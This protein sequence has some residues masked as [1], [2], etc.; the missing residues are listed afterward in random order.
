VGLEELDWSGTSARAGSSVYV[1]AMNCCL[2][3][4]ILL[5]YTVV[6]I[7]LTVCMCIRLCGVG[8]QKRASLRD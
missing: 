1:A 7:L 3:V 5:R 8:G 2:C 6:T 4:M